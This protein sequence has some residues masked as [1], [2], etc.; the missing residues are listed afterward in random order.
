MDAELKK[1]EE[2]YTGEPNTGC[3]LW[4]EELTDDG[5]ALLAVDGRAVL[6]H[7]IIYELT[8]GPVSQG[9]RL[10]RL[11]GMSCCGNPDHLVKT[12]HH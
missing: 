6:A 3:W 10:K 9:Y 4:N 12:A 1:L 7:E 11:C 5:D 2:F 8:Y